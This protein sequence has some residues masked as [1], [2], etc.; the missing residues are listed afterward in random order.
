MTPQQLLDV[1]AF[2]EHLTNMEL[3]TSIEVEDEDEMVVGDV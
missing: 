3:T 2:C 1:N